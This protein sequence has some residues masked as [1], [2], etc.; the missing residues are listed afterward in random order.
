MQ[1]IREGGLEFKDGKS[2]SKM[3]EAAREAAKALGLKIFLNNLRIQLRLLF[4]LK[5]LNLQILLKL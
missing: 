2:Y 5:I 1:L 3:A 4:L